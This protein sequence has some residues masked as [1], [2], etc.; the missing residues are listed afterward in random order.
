MHPHTII[1]MKSFVDQRLFWAE[2]ISVPVNAVSTLNKQNTFGS[3]CEPL[4][5]KNSSILE[6]FGFHRR[7]S[8]VH[9]KFND[10]PVLQDV[11]V[12]VRQHF[13]THF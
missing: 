9:I 11:I 2:K 8:C 5:L 6:H 12:Q 10:D 13:C 3:N 7:F 1:C 4:S